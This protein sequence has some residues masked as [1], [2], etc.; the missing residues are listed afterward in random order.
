MFIRVLPVPE[1]AEAAEAP[2]AGG[3]VSARGLRSR[4]TAGWSA[5]VSPLAIGAFGAA[6][7]AIGPFPGAGGGAR[8][9]P[10]GGGSR[11][12]G[13]PEDGIY[14]EKRLIESVAQDASAIPRP[15]VTKTKRLLD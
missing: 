5:E 15:R 11:A 8:A 9:R 2:E 12:V 13:N 6:A 14:A 4:R 3:G 10:D 7:A 1:A